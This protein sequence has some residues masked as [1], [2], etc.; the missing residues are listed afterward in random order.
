MRQTIAAVP[1]GLVLAASAGC[2]GSR[3][4][5]PPASAEPT[6]DES[7]EAA[8]AA[9]PGGTFQ[10][11]ALDNDRDA[12]DWEKPR[13]EV[14]V[15]PFRIDRHEVTVGA[16]EAAVEAGVVSAPGCSPYTEWGERLCNWG[17]ADRRD[18]PVNGVSWE[19]ANAYCQWKGKRLPTEAEFELLLRRGDQDAIYPWGNDLPP[20][21]GYGNYAD[22]N[23]PLE[24]A[25]G[26]Q[27][28]GYDDGHALT[29]P[30]ASFAPDA[31]G[32]HDVSGNIWE[33]CSD[34]FDPQYYACSPATDPKGPDHGQRK[35]LKGGNFF[36]IREELRISERHH[37]KP[38]DEAVYTGFRCA[39]DADGP[40]AR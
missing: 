40:G 37:K 1:L 18:H 8:L 12:R 17:K 20:P 9:I 29:A 33:W 3:D 39:A 5:A 25:E 32:V 11:G 16:Y 21:A 28:A 36:C 13:H 15:G 22:V 27:L 26:P 10:M 24:N 2:G 31:F 7:K 4:A 34:W 38:T 35:I 19:A 30:V 23:A 6:T 14:T